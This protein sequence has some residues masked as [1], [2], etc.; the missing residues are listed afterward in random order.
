[1]Y[2]AFGN[3][4]VDSTEFKKKIENETDFKVLKDMSKG[5]KREDI[6]AYNLSLSV[7]ILK[8]MVVEQGYNIEDL[9]ED[10][11]FDE[12]LTM[13]EDLALDLEELINDDSIV[14]IKA[15]KWDESYNDI[16]LVAVFASY[17]LPDVK[18]RDIMRRL[19]TQ[20][21]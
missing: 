12:Y 15:Y 8:E 11:L 18:V 13:A 4:V 7:D 14:D 20:V 2:V 9:S 17:E 10:E 16:R 1:M 5:S 6:L 21:E 19:L 3:E